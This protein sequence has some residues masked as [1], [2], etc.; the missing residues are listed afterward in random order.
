MGALQAW[1]QRARSRNWVRRS[2]IGLAVVAVL[3]LLLAFAAPP[4]VRGIAERQL[5]D[6]LQRPVHIAAV[7]I[8]P[9]RLAASVDGLKVEG[10]KGDPPLLEFDHLQVNVESS[11]LFRRALVLSQLRLERP[12]VHL[13]RTGPNTY[14]DRKSVV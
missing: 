3:M 8:N 12:R 5:G 10:L 1:F 9:L 7:H 2:A 11:S 13:A 4:L 14:T 6:L